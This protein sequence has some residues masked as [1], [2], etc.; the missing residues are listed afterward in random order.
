MS[1]APIVVQPPASIV[2][3]PKSTGT[4]AAS[5]APGVRA[6]TATTAGTAVNPAL[7]GLD[8]KIALKAKEL[9]QKEAD[10]KEYQAAQEKNLLDLESR[11]TE[12]LLGK[13]SRGIQAVAK[14]EGISVVVDKSG[15]VFGHDAVDLTEKVLKYL[16]NPAP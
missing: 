2:E 16:Q 10:Y 13:I 4:I 11:K 5:T 14:A 9:G 8:A 12:I 7:V 3:A 6:S 15:I 1:T